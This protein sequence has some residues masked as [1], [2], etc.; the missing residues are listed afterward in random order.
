MYA[1]VVDHVGERERLHRVDLPDPEVLPGQVVV[2]V[3]AV[4]CNF[5]DLL[6]V[7]GKYQLKPPLP[8]SPGTEVA[9]VV[10]AVGEGVGDIRPGQRV[11]AMLDWGGYASVVAAPAAF[12]VPLPD[13]MPYEVGA[14]F[15][16]AYQTAYLALT[17]RAALQAGE[18]LL[19]HGAAGGVGLAAV[20]VGCALG[21]RVFGTAGSLQKCEVV[22]QHGAEACFQVDAEDWVQA[23]NRASNGRGADVIYDPV[24]GTTFDRSLR[25]IA[26]CGRLVVIGFASGDIPRL[27]MNRVLLKNISVVGLNLGAYK[28]Q[29]PATLVRSLEALFRLYERGVLRPEI[30]ASLELERANEA[31]ALIRERKS[32]GKVVLIP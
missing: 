28:A 4:G 25:C 9:G 3:K 17:H 20:D 21:A 8:F 10:R 27:P 26:W 18:V 13:S 29:E 11:V 14:A 12:V 6:M 23:V 2:D 5:S 31:M 16:V 7:E 30:S 24:G 1:M 15:G 19:V 22:M 32:V